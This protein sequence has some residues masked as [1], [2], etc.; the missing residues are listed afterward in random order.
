[1][2]LP[3]MSDR[4]VL[5]ALAAYRDEHNLSF[6]ALAEQMAAHGVGVRGRLLHLALTGRLKTQP[7]ARTMFRLRRFAMAVARRKARRRR[8]AA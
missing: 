5:Q 1:M 6:D 2:P 7:Y 3:Q 4:Q 8:V